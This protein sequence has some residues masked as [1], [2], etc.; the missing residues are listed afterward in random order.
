MEETPQCKSTQVRKNKRLTP[1]MED[2][3]E[4]LSDLDQENK[5][6]RVRDIAKRLGVKMPSV[7]SMLKTLKE[8]GLIHYEKYEYVEL[9]DS[10]ATVGLEMR[11]RHQ[12]LFQFLVDILKVDSETAD[13]EACRMEHALSE[14]TLDRFTDFMEFVQVC[15][16]TGENWIDRFQDFRLHGHRPEKCEANRARFEKEFCR[17]VDCLE[18]EPAGE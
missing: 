7:T 2:Y 10:G 12:V 16:R 8:R 17:R 1:V 15:P 6:I 18:R 3:L 9:T 5:A 14:D 4:V 13:E 11:R